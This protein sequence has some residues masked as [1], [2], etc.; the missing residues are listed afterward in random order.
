M[1]TVALTQFKG[2]SLVA[3]KNMPLTTVYLHIIAF[4]VHAKTQSRI[5]TSMAESGYLKMA[6]L[7][8]SGI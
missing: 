5:K 6:L 4:T 8:S 3:V 7:R 2:E 1:K